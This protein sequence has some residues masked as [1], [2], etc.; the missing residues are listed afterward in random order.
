P[1]LGPYFFLLLLTSVTHSAPATFQLLASC[2]SWLSE[3]SSKDGVGSDKVLGLID[4]Q[5][6]R[7]DERM[8]EGRGGSLTQAN[9]ERQRGTTCSAMQP[10]TA[11]QQF[12]PPLTQ[13]Q[14]TLSLATCL[15][16]YKKQGKPPLSEEG[17]HYPLH[18]HAHI[19]TQ[20]YN[21]TAPSPCPPR[22]PEGQAL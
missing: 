9:T 7:L 11:P 5:S 21:C 13:C 19:S 4:G 14:W 2:L 17:R 16:K 6:W 15:V 20:Q 1:S 3:L 12:S 10:L 18:I 22:T 8:D